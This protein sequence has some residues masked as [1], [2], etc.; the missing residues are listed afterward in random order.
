MKITIILKAELHKIQGESEIQNVQQ[1]NV[2]GDLF[3]QIQTRLSIFS[4]K[5]QPKPLFPADPVLNQHLR[6][7]EM[8]QQS[9]QAPASSPSSNNPESAHEPKGE[10]GRPRN[11]HGVPTETRKYPHWWERQPVGFIQTV[12]KQGMEKT[13]LTFYTKR[14]TCQTMIKRTLSKILVFLL[15]ELD[16]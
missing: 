4:D 10:V 11:D 1:Q 15:G 14:K 9:R 5:R 12:I 16:N 3:N 7:V 13:T 6:S 8:S 2:I